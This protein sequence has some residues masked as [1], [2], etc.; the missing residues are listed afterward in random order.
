ML[1][2]SHVI[3]YNFENYG[4]FM[5]TSYLYLVL[6]FY[7]SFS[8]NYN[9]GILEHICCGNR[10]NYV[11]TRMGNGRTNSQSKNYDQSGKELEQ[12]V[13]I[14]NPVEETDIGRLPYLQALKR[15][16]V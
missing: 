2:Y 11:H 3:F 8:D 10:Y 15:A 4:I 7:S 5:S 12:V 14:G 6:Y 16:S 9:F 1:Y 13:S